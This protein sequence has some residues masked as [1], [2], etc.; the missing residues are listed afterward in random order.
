MDWWQL[1]VDL[2]QAIFERQVLLP[3]SVEALGGVI[4]RFLEQSLGEG[5]I[6]T[7]DA[8]SFTLANP[9]VQGAHDSN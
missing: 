6:L 1:D 5:V 2:L 8:L 7:L 3:L 9:Q 4:W